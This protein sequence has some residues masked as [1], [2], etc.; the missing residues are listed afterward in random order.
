[1]PFFLAG[2][3]EGVIFIAGL[4]AVYGQKTFFSL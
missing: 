1:M 4:W 2:P 3:E